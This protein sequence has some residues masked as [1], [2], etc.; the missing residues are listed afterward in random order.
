M[1]LSSLFFTWEPYSS[2]SES[3]SWNPFGSR[4]AQIGENIKNLKW[5]K[6]AYFFQVH[7]FLNLQVFARKFLL[8][9]L[10]ETLNP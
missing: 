9:A 7:S 5:F 1:Q 4:E 3:R 6:A 2:G 8:A 10:Y